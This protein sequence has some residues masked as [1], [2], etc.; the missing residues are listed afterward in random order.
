MPEPDKVA[1]VAEPETWTWKI[2]LANLAIF[3]VVV[4]VAHSIAF[5]AVGNQ[6]V[7]DAVWPVAATCVLK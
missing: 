2:F 6:H 3:S 5:S 1:L 7:A 4:A